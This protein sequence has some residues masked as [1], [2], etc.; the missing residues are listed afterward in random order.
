MSS[1][2]DLARRFW[3]PLRLLI[4]RYRVTH[5]ERVFLRSIVPPSPHTGGTG[6]VVLVEAVE[7]HYYLALLAHVVAGLA[8]ERTIETQQLVSRSLRPGS[9]RSVLQAVK[10]LCFYNA[11]TDWKWIRLYAAFCGRVA[12]RSASPLMS[13]SCLDDF[14][15]ARRIW[16]KLESM[17]SLLSLKISEIAVGDLIYD[18]YLRFK[19]AATVDLKSRYLRIVIWQ[20]LRDL[21]AARAYMSA[22]KP[23]IFLTSYSTYIQHGI[24]VRVALAA[25]VKVFA[26]G[27]FQEFYKQLHVTD[28]VHTRN[29]DGYRAGF[30]RL[31]NPA[32]KLVDA[33]KSL[34]A[35]LSGTND[36]AT[37]YMRRSAY[38]GSAAALP[39]GLSGA[40]VLFLHDFFD[41]PHCYRWMLFPD[42]LVWTRLTLNLARREHIKIFVKPH[43]NQVADSKSIVGRL[44][45][46]YPE[47]K[48]L[49][50]SVSNVQLTA[51]GIACAVTIYGTVAHEMAYLGVPSIAAGHNPH[52]GFSF[53][54]TAQNRDEYDRLILNYRNLPRSPERL[55]RESLEFYCM[56]NL[57]DA[58]DEQSLRNTVIRFRMQVINK[59]GWVYDGNDFLS[60]SQQL[61]AEPAFHKACR[62]MAAHLCDEPSG[63][64]CQDGAAE[65]RH[66]ATTG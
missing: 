65:I 53:C 25:G 59:G 55:H 12:Y 41:S 29:P 2:A 18:T 37:A 57:A 47:A 33:E 28:W 49:S 22:A 52:V 8:A 48:W 39:E 30:A 62:K 63:E 5:A 24:A 31:E 20:A 7:D 46:E 26:F 60:F 34:A 50:T 64:R 44:M 36:A 17:E 66:Q 45:S 43:P 61:T 40:L 42:F 51:A 13:R 10:S 56:H 9:T 6:T 19:P 14:L 54:H 23:K 21:R 35:R 4:D 38:E 15:E 11:F 27:N 3:K 16:S 1:L 58:G 32:S